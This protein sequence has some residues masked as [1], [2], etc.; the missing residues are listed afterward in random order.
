[1]TTELT[2]WYWGLVAIIKL[3]QL[4]LAPFDSSIWGPLCVLIMNG[5]FHK[6][7]KKFAF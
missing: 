4:C 2:T 5:L 1:M 7:I 6:D 3:V